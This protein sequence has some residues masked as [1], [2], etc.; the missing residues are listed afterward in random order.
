MNSGV[1]KSGSP[2]PRSIIVRPAAFSALARAETAMV[3][4]SLSWATFAEGVNSGAGVM[5]AL[6]RVGFVVAGAM[7]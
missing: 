6:V 3:A 2:A 7:R 5:R 1:S 4:D